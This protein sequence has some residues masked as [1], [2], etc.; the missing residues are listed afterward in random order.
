MSER[1]SFHYP[2]IRTILPVLAAV[3]TLM[4]SA[5]NDKELGT[6]P[7][8]EEIK[9]G[10]IDMNLSAKGKQIFVSKCIQ[11]HQIET[12]MV[13]PS[14][15][16]V[17]KRRRPEWIMNQILDPAAMLQNDPISKELF[18]QYKIPMVYQDIKEDEARAL[19]EY[20]RAIDNGKITP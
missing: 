15:K 13:G 8:K 1:I 5:C 14:L 17:T 20:F 10:E 2:K 19:L 12:R 3:I 16:D 4:I 18:A 9:L 7:I 6:G 11:C